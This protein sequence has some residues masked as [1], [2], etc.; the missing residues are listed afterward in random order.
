M[1]SPI[2]QRTFTHQFLE[3][4]EFRDAERR[5]AVLGQ[6]PDLVS[7]SRDDVTLYNRL[8]NVLFD[9]IRRAKAI[10]IMRLDSDSD[11]IEVDYW[12][13]KSFAE[14]DFNPSEKLVRHSISTGEPYLHIWNEKSPGN[15]AYTSTFKTTGRSLI[16]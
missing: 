2:S 1:P 9:G 3:Q 13:R 11:K 14:Q 4:V 16:H 7:S 5:L 6:L 15:A 12:D 10:A 8:V